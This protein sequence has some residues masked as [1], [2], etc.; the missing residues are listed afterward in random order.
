MTS[1]RWIAFGALWMAVAVVLGA[2]GAHALEAR[3]EEAGQVDNWQTAVRYQ[4]WHALALVAFGL[5]RES[6]L[7]GGLSGWCF[8]LGSLLF[9]GSIYCLSLDVLRPLMGPITPLGGL[10]LI[11]GWVVLA[12]Q[13]FRSRPSPT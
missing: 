3:L 6:H 7:G 4:A 9:S 13:A 8:L 2:F 5:Y 10:F 1:T 11:V 12:V